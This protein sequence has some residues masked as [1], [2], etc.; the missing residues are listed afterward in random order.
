[1]AA[2]G[3]PFLIA[4]KKKRKKSW[5]RGLG[6][7]SEGVCLVYVHD[8]YACVF[9]MRDLK[10]RKKRRIEKADEHT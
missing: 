4:K 10:K 3:I 2:R 5:G 6:F 1:M 9:R 7:I 8:I